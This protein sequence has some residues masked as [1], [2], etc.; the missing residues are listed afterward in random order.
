MARAAEMYGRN[1]AVAN[2]LR[3]A[4]KTVSSDGEYRRVMNALERQNPTI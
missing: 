1:R 2:E 3:T 4:V